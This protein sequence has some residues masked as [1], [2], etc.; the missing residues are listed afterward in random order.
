MLKKNFEPLFNELETNDELLNYR[1]LA[2]TFLRRIESNTTLSYVEYTSLIHLNNVNF[3]NI[4]NSN[5][6]ILPYTDG[7]YDL[8]NKS[9]NN[10]NS[11]QYLTINFA[12]EYS[13]T[14]DTKEVYDIFST[15]F[16]N[17]D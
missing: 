4:L 6:S 9:F 14:A 8:F 15:I 5:L 16:I 13:Y 7:F 2:S 3:K 1:R 17:S 12:F 10:C 11:N